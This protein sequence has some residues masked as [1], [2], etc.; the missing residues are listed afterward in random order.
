MPFTPI[1]QG[2]N[3]LV[4][5]CFVRYNVRIKTMFGSSLPPVVCR[6][7]SCFIHV[8]CACLR[9]AVSNTYC[10]VFLYYLSSSCIPYVASFSG[11]FNFDWR[12]GIL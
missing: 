9:I 8:I 4:P 5:C 6:R 10:V 11:L 2:D 3:Y 7:V 12:F 1:L